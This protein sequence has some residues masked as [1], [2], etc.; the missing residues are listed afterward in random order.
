MLDVWQRSLHY[1]YLWIT[2]TY[3]KG[4]LDKRL[5]KK[6]APL[7]LRHK[8]KALL[9][10][11]KMGILFR[12]WKCTSDFT[13][14]D[15]ILHCIF[16]LSV[17]FRCMVTKQHNSI[18][19]IW[20]W[21][22]THFLYIYMY[23]TSLINLLRLKHSWSKTFS[24]NLI[25]SIFYDFNIFTMSRACDIVPVCVEEWYHKTLNSWRCTCK[26]K[27]RIMYNCVKEGQ[28]EDYS[29]LGFESL[30]VRSRGSLLGRHTGGQGPAGH[31]RSRIIFP[32]FLL[33]PKT[34]LLCIRWFLFP[35]LLSYV[36]PRTKSVVGIWPGFL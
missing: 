30:P 5:A 19:I 33:L 3:P 34:W 14:V 35:L 2:S 12:K 10:E 4:E 22:Q 6:Q 31:Y 20:Y 23:L 32:I 25:F 36:V 18:L 28:N 17:S 27:R 26:I 21:F 13:A 15:L 7:C 16:G 9:T 29:W 24:Y 8:V 11:W 1:L